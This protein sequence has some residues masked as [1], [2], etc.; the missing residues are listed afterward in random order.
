MVNIEMDLTGM[1][2]GVLC[3]CEN[4]HGTSDYMTGE[5]K[6]LRPLQPVYNCCP[7]IETF[8]V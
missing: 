6:L 4:G 7:L 3:C 2:C 5:S 1:E 8:A